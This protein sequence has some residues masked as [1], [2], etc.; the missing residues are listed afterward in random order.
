MF[1]MK[2]I[3]T[4]ID[5][6]RQEILINVIICVDSK[7]FNEGTESNFTTFTTCF[8]KDTLPIVIIYRKYFS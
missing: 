5:S 4:H 1:K 2:Y 7:N 3:A 6:D 8:I